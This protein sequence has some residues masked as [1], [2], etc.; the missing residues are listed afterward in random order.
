MEED[1]RHLRKRAMVIRA[2]PAVLLEGISIIP[3]HDLLPQLAMIV[4]KSLH[5]HRLKHAYAHAPSGYSCKLG[6]G[7]HQNWAPEQ[8]VAVD[9]APGPAW[10]DLMS[11]PRGCEGR[12]FDSK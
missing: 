11:F 3:S 7:W 5:M 8:R 12:G 9:W 4:E 10:V 2:P 1:G 6:L